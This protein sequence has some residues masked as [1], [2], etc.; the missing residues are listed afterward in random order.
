MLQVLMYDIIVFENSAFVRPQVNDFKPEF[1]KIFT[2]KSVFEKM[3]FRWPFS[4]NTWAGTVVQTEEK[5]IR[6]QAKTDTCG[7]GLKLLG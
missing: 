4:P 5:N 1:S 3:R 6:F 7:R 2:L